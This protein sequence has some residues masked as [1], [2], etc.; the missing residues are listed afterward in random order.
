[1]LST[2]VELSWGGSL[3]HESLHGPSNGAGFSFPLFYSMCHMAASFVGASLIFLCQPSSNRVT[4][5]QLRN[6]GPSLFLLSLLFALNIC[7]GPPFE[8]RRRRSA[9]RLIPCSPPRALSGGN[10]AS[11]VTLGIAVNQLVK[12]VTPLPS[13]LFAY[14][15]QRRTFSAQVSEHPKPEPLT[16][17]VRP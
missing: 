1:M 15:L 13:M 5:Q 14:A 6:H 12:S 4:L 9:D 16:P 8:P 3:I 2:Q 7:N 17:N 10:N 11:L